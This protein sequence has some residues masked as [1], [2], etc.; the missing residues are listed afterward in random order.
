M[1]GAFILALVMPWWQTLGPVPIQ[2][3]IR[4]QDKEY[5]D[6]ILEVHIG[7]DHVNITLVEDN[8]VVDPPAKND[9]VVLTRLLPRNSQISS[10]SDD[11]DDEEYNARPE[12][13]FNE[14][15]R[16]STADEMRDQL[17]SSLERGLPEPMLTVV[18]YLSW[19]EE[20]FRWSVDF[21]R[22]GYICQFVLTLAL[23]CWAWMNIFFLVIPQHGAVAM[24][25]TGLLALLAVFLYWILLPARNLAITINGSLLETKLDGCYW[26]VLTTGLVALITGAALLAVEIRHPGSLTFDLEIDSELKIK[27]IDKV[28]ERRSIKL[29]P[30]STQSTASGGV[31]KLSLK[32][33]ISVVDATAPDPG[34][35]ETTTTSAALDAIQADSGL[36]TTVNTEMTSD[37]DQIATLNGSYLKS[38]VTNVS[39]FHFPS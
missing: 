26:T 23:I 24:M 12:I 4:V 38:T 8:V 37:F 30:S 27:L 29:Q 22:A 28:V 14:Q 21:R 20:G 16:L 5:M 17:R 10:K 19:Q 3:P 34:Y 18:S 32:S 1:G 31:H 33:R 36:V 35:S 13:R 25:A 9:K 11:D 7:L 2:A 39:P 15:I 6:L